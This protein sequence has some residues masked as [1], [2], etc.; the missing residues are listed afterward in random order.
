MP[1]AMWWTRPEPLGL[2]GRPGAQL[3]GRILELHP[4]GFGNAAAQQT[5]LVQALR[6]GSPLTAQQR[7]DRTGAQ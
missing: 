2:R 5:A 7:P 3:S 1:P 4:A 6:R